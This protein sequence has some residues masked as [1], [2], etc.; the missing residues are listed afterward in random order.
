MVKDLKQTDLKFNIIKE[1]INN[2][3]I[4]LIFSI[5]PT[6][7]HISCHGDYQRLKNEFFLYFEDSRKGHIGESRKYLEKIL[8]VDLKNIKSR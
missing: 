8:K 4:N 2:E 5:S 3:S 7:L 6:I 1:T